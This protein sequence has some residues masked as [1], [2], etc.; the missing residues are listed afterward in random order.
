M[1]IGV[2]VT[3]ENPRF[4]D[5]VFRRARD[6]G[7][8][9]GQVNFAWSP[10]TPDIIADAARSA[11]RH[12]FRVVA[13]GCLANLLRLAEGWIVGGDENDL[14]TM[15]RSLKAFPE[16]GKIA[17]WSGTYARKWTEPN[18]L[19]QG[20]DAYYA[21][22]FE[23]QR[24]LGQLPD[25]GVTIALQPCYAHI[26]HDVATTLRLSEDFDEGRVCLDLDPAYMIAPTLYSK[27]PQVLT[28]IVS[29]L[30]PMAT[31]VTLSDLIIRET[32]VSHPLPG[33]GTLDFRALLRAVD[34]NA[35][36]DA[37]R[38]INPHPTASIEELLAA[39]QY[40]DDC[41]TV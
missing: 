14:L 15:G 13:V 41:T 20:E 1:Q 29:A 37:P 25:G 2:V 11:A 19:N 39:R 21:M 18:L 40:I 36:I 5:V 38:L 10:L 34:E 16:C 24:L 8:D 30:A 28:Q 33:R 27:Y 26:L 35:P 12:G 23:L 6:A 3:I 7:Y 17:L 31:M 22:V 9:F 32:S 4:A